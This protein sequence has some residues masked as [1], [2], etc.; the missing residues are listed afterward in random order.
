MISH[1]H[2]V[3]VRQI[4]NMG[5]D[6]EKEL[7]EAVLHVLGDKCTDIVARIKPGLGVELLRLLTCRLDPLVPNLK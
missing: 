7:Y 6:Q 4:W 5:G 2:Y 3:D 1:K